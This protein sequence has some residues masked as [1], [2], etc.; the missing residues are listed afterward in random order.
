MPYLSLEPLT[1]SED[2]FIL[3]DSVQIN[4]QKIQDY[5]NMLKDATNPTGTLIGLATAT[6]PAGYLLA[7]GSA[8][9][10][11]AYPGL[12]SYIGGTT[13]PDYRGR[14][15]VGRDG[16]TEFATLGQTGGVKSIT[17]G[18]GNLPVHT[19]GLNGHTHGGAISGGGLGTHGHTVNSH[20]HGGG[21]GFHAHTV[22]SVVQTSTGGHIHDNTPGQIAG[23]P[24]GAISF[25]GTA[26]P[27]TDSVGVANTFETP[28][29]DAPNLS[30]SHG[31]N[32]D[33][34]NTTDGGFANTAIATLPPYRV[35]NWYIKT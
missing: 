7:D 9:S 22:G 3:R 19:H 8:F 21:T 24:N 20:N 27:G 17:V 32:G 29:T 14:F 15:L 6:A 13:L 35:L 1:T 23:R 18:S 5:I 10:G 31:I 4:L 28:G 16:T 12:A 2:F 11:T 34:G 33:S 30:H 26:G 25:T